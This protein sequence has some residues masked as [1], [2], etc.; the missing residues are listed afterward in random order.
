M[1]RFSSESCM[2]CH[3]PRLPGET[4]KEGLAI[5]H[6]T[7]L[8]AFSNL[9]ICSKRPNR[10]MLECPALTYLYA[11]RLIPISSL[12][13][14]SWRD[15][16]PTVWPFDHCIIIPMSVKPYP[17]ETVSLSQIQ[18]RICRGFSVT[19]RSPIPTTERSEPLP[20]ALTLVM[21]VVRT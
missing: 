8:I 1:I 4:A 3:P 9:R 20:S 15:H 14:A 2:V 7:G 16:Y 12:L 19:A 21:L 6:P 10:G 18:F 13:A 11:V 5:S 17:R